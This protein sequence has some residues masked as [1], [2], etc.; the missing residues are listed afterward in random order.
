MPE[1]KLKRP[2]QCK[3]CHIY[4]AQKNGLQRHLR[5]EHSNLKSKTEPTAENT[6]NPVAQK[7]L[8]CE[9]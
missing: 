8:Q 3:I 6:G 1:M 5:N 2:F 4:F 9:K 7:P